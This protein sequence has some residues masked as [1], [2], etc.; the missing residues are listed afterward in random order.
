MERGT[1]NAPRR[2]ADLPGPRGLPLLGNFHQ[3]R[4]GV[5]HQ[6]LERWADRH[7][8]IYRMSLGRRKHVV[9]FDTDAIGRILGKRPHGFRRARPLAAVAEEMGLAGVFAAEGEEWRRRRRWERAADHG[10]AIDPCRDLMRF[11]ARVTMRLAF[12]VDPDAPG[13]PGAS[14][15][16]H[17]AAIFPVLH[18][19]LNMPLPL[20]R[21][22][23][24]PSDHVLERALDGLKTEVCDMIRAARERMTENPQLRFSPGNF[25]EAAITASDE[26]EPVFSDDEIFADAVPLLLAGEDTTANTL[27][28]ALHYL[29]RYP[30]HFERLRAEAQEALGPARNASMLAQLERLPFHDAF[31][32]EVMRLKP[33]A[34]FMGLEPNQDVEILGCR[35]P[36]GTPLFLLTR[37][38]ASR[39]GRLAR[40][41][42]KH[43]PDAVFFPF[44]G[45]P[46]LCPGRNLALCEMRAVLAMVCVNFEVEAASPPEYVRERL[47]FTMAPENLTVRL[48]RRERS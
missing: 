42:P 5:L 31:L 41:H 40:F 22:F 12:G 30:E 9:V 11:T 4:L 17:L 2:F 47:S 21:W 36:A 35:I 19:R 28:W 14:I 26:G 24:L 16:R 33:V 20:W 44:G 45:G 15:R 39:G 18:R 25:L 6:I 34:P 37:H 46:R 3:V 13:S 32:S 43:P 48:G 23:R 29:T 7:G 8:P 27:A 38:V 1:G 10:E